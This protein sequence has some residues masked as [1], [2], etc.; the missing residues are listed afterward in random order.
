ME[1]GRDNRRLEQLLASYGADPARWPAADQTERSNLVSAVG[2][3]ASEIDYV[4]AL[5]TTPRLPHGATDR[6]MQ[7]LGTPA[8][9]E[10]IMFRAKPHKHGVLA[11][12]AA[13]LPLAASLALGIYLGTQGLLDSF[14]PS[15]LT[16]DVAGITLDDSIDDLGGVGEADTYAEENLT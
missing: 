6:L 16:G 12:Y 15:T 3:E 2:H 9:A 13:T 8:A 10:V 5:A 7:S 11:R 4:L 14:L 1:Y